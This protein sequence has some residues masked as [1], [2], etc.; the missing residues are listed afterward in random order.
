MTTL[1]NKKINTKIAN[2]NIQEYPVS[3]TNILRKLKIDLK[4]ISKNDY[5]S[6]SIQKLDD[7]SY[8]II[9]NKEHTIERQ[10]F[11]VAHEI[12]HFLLH[13]DDIDERAEHIVQDFSDTYVLR[14]VG[15]KSS[16]SLDAKKELE[17]NEFAARLLM[18]KNKVMEQLKQLTQFNHE[19]T[20]EDY[21]RLLS[22]YFIVSKE[23]MKIRINNILYFNN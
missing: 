20:L 8:E 19:Y 3:L 18:P 16:N 22:T 21:S 10:R 5:F 6:G 11:T 2:L 9:V 13:K 23:A 17:A 7:D 1:D 15:R 4:L 12:G 14:S